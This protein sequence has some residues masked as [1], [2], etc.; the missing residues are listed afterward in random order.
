M[1]ISLNSHNNTRKETFSQGNTPDD[2]AQ[3]SFDNALQIYTLLNKSNCKECHLPTCMAFAGAVYT[4]SRQL[5]DCPHLSSDILQQYGDAEGGSHALAENTKKALEELKKAVAEIDL[6]S[7]AEQ[8]GGTYS[9]GKLT[10]KVLG[11]NFSVADNGDI[12]TD[13]HVIPW[14]TLPVYNYILRGGKSKVSGR[15]VPLRELPSGQDWFRLFGQR[16]EKPLK[17]IADHYPDLFEDMVR[18]FNGRQGQNHYQSDVS[19][20]LHPLPKLPMLICYWHPENEL[21][22]DLNLFFDATA[23]DYLDLNSINSLGSGFVT[24]LEK[25]L[26]RHG[27]KN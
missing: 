24:M 7:I 16:C 21:E 13:I 1:R 11:K 14:V 25:L 2:M 9:N 4:G 15:W 10:L 22:S 12:H 26:L 6:Q 23:E 8:I 17:K 19:V 27:N 20:V 5:R 3:K 18:L